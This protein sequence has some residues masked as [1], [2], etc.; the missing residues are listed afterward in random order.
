MPANTELRTAS[1]E[2]RRSLPLALLILLSIVGLFAFRVWFRLSTYGGGNAAILLDAVVIGLPLL[3]FFFLKQKLLVLLSPQIAILVLLLLGMGAIFRDS[4][5]SGWLRIGS[6]SLCLPALLCFLIFPLS[7]TTA[8]SKSISIGRGFMM[9]GAFGFLPAV[10]ILLHAVMDD[11]AVYFFACAAFV[12]YVRREGRLDLPR[13]L[14]IVCAALFSAI[15]LAL[16]LSPY[17]RY[18]DIILSRGAADP[19]GLGCRLHAMDG[20]WSSIRLAGASPLLADHGEALEDLLQRSAYAPFGVLLAGGWLAFAG[21]LVCFFVL[22]VCLYRLPRRMNS[23]FSRFVAFLVPS[24]FL[25]RAVWNLCSCFFGLYA[26]QRLPLFGGSFTMLL[27]DGILLAIDL[28]LY[29]QRNVPLPAYFYPGPAPAEAADEGHAQFSS[30]ILRNLAR[31]IN[32]EADAVLP[33][34]PAQPGGSVQSRKT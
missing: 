6:I 9:L 8:R 28:G 23:D 3:L 30:P 14:F 13:W 25:G 33:A 26:E 32:P 31:I 18:A 22:I 17:L 21:L 16:I 4:I 15:I 19:D 5:Y 20:C 1:P 10:L 27:I 24:L 34:E 29:R 7:S 12:F 11:V 2:P